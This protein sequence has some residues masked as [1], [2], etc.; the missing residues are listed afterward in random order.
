MKI[1]YNDYLAEECTLT[2]EELPEFAEW[3]YSN[4]NDLKKAYGRNKLWIVK[5][6]NWSNLNSYEEGLFNKSK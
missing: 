4:L 1:S 3:G 2:Y 6:S 5:K